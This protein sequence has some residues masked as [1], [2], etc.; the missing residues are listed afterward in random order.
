MTLTRRQLLQASGATGAALL[1]SGRAPSWAAPG[2]IKK[3]VDPLPIPGVITGNAQLSMVSSSHRFSS[4][5]PSASPTLAYLPSGSTASDAYLGPTIV[6]TTGQPTTLSMANSMGAH[7][8]AIDTGLA[9]ARAEDATA[10]RGST[11]LHGGNTAPAHDGGPADF[12]GVGESHDYVYP[13]TQDAAGLWYH[14]HALG[15]TRLNVYAGLAG[16]YLIRDTAATGIDTG[17]GTVLPAGAYEIP[18]IIQDKSFDA[19]GRMVYPATW[20][21]EFFGDTAVVNGVAFPYLAVDQGIYR[22]R[23]YNGSNARFY[24]LALKVKATGAIR[25]FRQIGSDGGLLNNPVQLSALLLAPGERADLLVDFRGLPAGALVEV[26]NNAVTPFPSGPHAAHLGGAPLP[27]IM[28]FR[29][30]GRTG[31][32]PSGGSITA[33][34]TLRPVTGVHRLD[35][36]AAART[37]SHSLVEIG[38]A[39][40]PMMALLNNRTFHTADYRTEPVIAGTMELWEFVNTT[41]DAHP[42]HPHLVQFQVLNRQAV[43][44]VAYLANYPTDPNGWI[45]P[46]QGHYPAPS[47]TPY[48]AGPVRPPAANELG[49]KDTVV[50]PPGSVTRVL[51]PFGSSGDVTP[52]AARNV[53]V[54]GADDNDY[55][56]HCHILEH[57]ENDMM[58]AYKIIAAT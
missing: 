52:I 29:V 33:A 42:I 34:T 25:P 50:V 46:D 55:A 22:F 12:F 54:P 53:Y 37:R 26:G 43:D 19:G 40:G 16:G 30:T 5:F 44:T 31:W 10:P 17:D 38:G 8:L 13:N 14:D 9:G 48:L 28:Q 41:V 1:V 58:Q 56:W 49:W 32:T 39:N 21:P 45:I 6:A 23:V 35:P 51:V 3:F 18:L 20:V 27:Q 24:R 47:P 4:S 2:L 36:G 15:I 11:H 57:E 7:P